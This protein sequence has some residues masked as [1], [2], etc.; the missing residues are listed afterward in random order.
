VAF[1]KG[2]FRRPLRVGDVVVPD[3][4]G[5]VTE[6]VARPY[7]NLHV[8]ELA[9]FVQPLAG[10]VAARRELLESLPFPVGYGVEIALLIDALRAVGLEGLA[11][12]DLGTRPEPPSAAARPHRHGAGRA[13][14]GGAAGA[15]R[16]GRRRG[17]AGPAAGARG[18]GAAA[19][20]RRRGRAAAAAGA[21]PSSVRAT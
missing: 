3:G 13:R 1:V 6:L 7:L 9:P 11:Q 16:G 19:A 4:G 2:A 17:G 15:R 8:P 14:G 12:V 5:R 18:R 21:H 20:V 10:E